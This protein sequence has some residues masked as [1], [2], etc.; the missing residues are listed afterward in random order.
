MKRLSHLIRDERGTS[1]IE[2]ALLAPILASLVVGMSDLSRAYSAKLQL[3]Q[4]AQRSIEKAMNGKKETTLYV[5]LE[6]EAV[7]AAGVDEA[8]VEVRFWLECDGVSQNTSSATMEEDYEIVCADGATIARYVNVR[9]EK[10]Y[11]PMFDVKWAG[12]NPDGSFTLV[13]E[14]GIRVQ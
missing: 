9:I 8:D 7:L 5:A 2:L 13:G 1:V 10:A 12:S 4:A 11:S 6:D 3:E 14:A